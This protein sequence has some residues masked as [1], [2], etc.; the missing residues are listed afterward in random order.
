MDKLIIT[1][2]E[3]DN[4]AYV[5]NLVAERGLTEVYER[6]ARERFI[7]E[8]CMPVIGNMDRM[9]VHVHAYLF[10]ECKRYA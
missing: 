10:P 5:R 9:P 2:T 8:Y 4:C 3:A 6:A 1:D 7:L